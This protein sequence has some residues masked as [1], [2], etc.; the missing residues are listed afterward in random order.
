MTLTSNLEIECWWEEEQN[1]IHLKKSFAEK[2]KTKKKWE[3]GHLRKLVCSLFFHFGM[4]ERSDFKVT[5]QKL[6]LELI[7]QWRQGEKKN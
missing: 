5:S 4:I 6:F 1:E 7:A 2:N 3:F